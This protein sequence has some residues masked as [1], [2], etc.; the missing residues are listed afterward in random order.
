METQID[1]LAKVEER[2]AGLQGAEDTSKAEKEE[3]KEQLEKIRRDVKEAQDWTVEPNQALKSLFFIFF[4]RNPFGIFLF[5][6]FL[7]QELGLPFA[8]KAEE[9]ASH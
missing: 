8:A 1:V 4:F 7:H 6:Y 2:E 5:S 3:L 9:A